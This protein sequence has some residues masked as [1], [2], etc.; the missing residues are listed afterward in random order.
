ML[1]KKTR[2]MHSCVRSFS[3]HGWQSAERYSCDMW[4]WC[5]CKGPSPPQL[6]QQVAALKRSS[7]SGVGVKVAL[8]ASK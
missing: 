2:T 7:S 1:W 4:S 8:R 5:I 6:A 3:L